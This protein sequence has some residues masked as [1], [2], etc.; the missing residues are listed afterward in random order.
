MWESMPRYDRPSSFLGI[1]MKLFE[2]SAYYTDYVNA[3]KKDLPNSW[4]K[5]QGAHHR[6]GHF[7][8]R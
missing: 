8:G 3:L 1:D 5:S 4:F 6:Q 7:F 2:D